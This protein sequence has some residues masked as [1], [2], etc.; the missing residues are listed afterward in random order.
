[1]KVIILDYNS[2]SGLFIDATSSGFLVDAT[3][4]VISSGPKFT[5]DFGLVASTQFYRSSLKVEW[6]VADLQSHIERQYL[7]LKSH[8]GGDFQHSSTQVKVIVHSH[9]AKKVKWIFEKKVLIF[10]FR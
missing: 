3:P 5:K 4:P 7:S 6:K 1:M 10:R 2:I 9:S 8:H